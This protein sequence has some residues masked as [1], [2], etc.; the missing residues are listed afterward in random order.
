MNLIVKTVEELVREGLVSEKEDGIAF[1]RFFNGTIA[2]I[3]PSK[4]AAV[5]FVI[6]ILLPQI[7]AEKLRS[8]WSCLTG[9][10]NGFV[11]AFSKTLGVVPDDG[12]KWLLFK[13]ED[14]E[15]TIKPC[16]D[17]TLPLF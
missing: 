6:S 11:D 10:M 4:L 9:P 13:K 8:I 2:L 17:P 7:G 1:Q 16:L 12:E 15:A 5:K 3:F 14:F